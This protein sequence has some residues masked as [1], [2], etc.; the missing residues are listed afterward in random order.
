ML[1]T[2]L[3]VL[4]V[5]D[6]GVPSCSAAEHRQFDFWLGSWSVTTPDGKPAGENVITSELKGCVLH[7]HW[8]GRGNNKGESF[9]IFDASSKRWHQTWVDDQG[10]LLV[11]EGVFADGKMTLVGGTKPMNRI[12]WSALPNGRVRQLWETS[13]DSGKTWAV[14]FDGTYQKKSS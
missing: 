9:N 13:S 4:L 12:I 8:V 3:A 7:E 5:A 6:A 14:A 10:S 11:L 1:T 2:L